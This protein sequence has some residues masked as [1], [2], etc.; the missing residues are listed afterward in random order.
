[1]GGR[2]APFLVR[3]LARRRAGEI[4][5]PITEAVPAI[6]DPHSDAELE[7]ILGFMR[8]SIEFL[9]EHS[10]TIRGLPAAEA[11][12]TRSPPPAAP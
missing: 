1:M 6:L 11:G 5:G 4:W 9:A 3:H 2:R 8:L 10:E 7:T 12:D